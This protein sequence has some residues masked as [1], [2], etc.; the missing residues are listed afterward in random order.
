M[1]DNLEHIGTM[2]F[3]IKDNKILLGKRKNSY[4][5]G[6]FGAPGGRMEITEK[7]IDAL[8][9]ELLEGI[10]IHI[11]SQSF[12][13][14]VRENQGDYSFIHI[15]FLVSEFEGDI[16]NNEPEKCESWEW[17]D[18]DKLPSDILPGHK[19]LIEMIIDPQLPRFADI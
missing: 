10:N 19:A 16:K 1:Q 18:L 15:G 17:Y 4:R 6:F 3:I 7:T 8:K 5:E 9:R 13:G 11:S 12:V 2:G 14:I